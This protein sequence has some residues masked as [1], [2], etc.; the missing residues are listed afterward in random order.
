MEILC[1][2]YPMAC[3]IKDKDGYL[4]IHLACE[5]GASSNVVRLLTTTYQPS[6][7]AT[8]KY[9]MTPLHFA[10]SHD[11]RKSVVQAILDAANEP[12]ICKATDSLGHTPLH[13]ALMALAEFEVVECLV[14]FCPETVWMKTNKGE[15]PLEIAKRKR[16]PKEYT[17]LLEH[18][19]ERILLE[20]NS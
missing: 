9:G 7:Y 4:P 15:L 11:P 12:T 5:N 1:R 2:K 3:Q 20:Q 17:E 8:C 10:A 13:M 14:T 16:A 19:M 6:V 18:E